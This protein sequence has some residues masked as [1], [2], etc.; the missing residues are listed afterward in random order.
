MKSS[1]STG[2]R[3]QELNENLKLLAQKPVSELHWGGLENTIA[4]SQKY[5]ILTR[6][7][8]I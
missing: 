8:P 3:Q 4:E 5:T 1:E 6:C 7:P 2:Y